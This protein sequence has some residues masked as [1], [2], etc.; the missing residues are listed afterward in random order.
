MLRKK[1]K[2]EKVIQGMEKIGCGVD[3]GK[4]HVGMAAR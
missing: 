3:V 1:R 2:L 4:H